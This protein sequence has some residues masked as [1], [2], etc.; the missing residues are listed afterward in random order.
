M[1]WIWVSLPHATYGLAVRDGKV[2]AA[3]PIGRW[4]V[5]KDEQYV[6]AYLRR[7][8]AQLIPLDQR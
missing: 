1:R 3:A 6:A 8:G 4:S 7:K 5:G 2:V